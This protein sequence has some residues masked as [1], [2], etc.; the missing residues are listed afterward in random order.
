MREP[1]QALKISQKI[2]PG[3][4]HLFNPTELAQLFFCQVNK[5]NP[6]PQSG[7]LPR[8][9]EIAEHYSTVHIVTILYQI[10][11]IHSI[12]NSIVTES[13]M[14]KTEIKRSEIYSFLL[15]SYRYK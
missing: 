4:L 7:W 2:F 13:W 14:L 6:L 11:L 10:H 5:P 12:Y 9:T 1:F 3:S 15:E 8:L